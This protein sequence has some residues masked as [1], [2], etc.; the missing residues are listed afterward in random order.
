MK[1]IELLNKKYSVELD[2]RPSSKKSFSKDFLAIS[3]AEGKNYKYAY[4]TE[5]LD[6][7]WIGLAKEKPVNIGIS[8]CR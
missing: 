7:V 8:P 4:I 2:W 1:E 5:H 3:K 6:D